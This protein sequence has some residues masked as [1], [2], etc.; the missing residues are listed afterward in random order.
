MKTRKIINTVLIIAL[1]IVAI[2]MV[3]ILLNN[4]NSPETVNYTELQQMIK[5]NGIT[6]VYVEGSYTVYARKVGSK[7]EES[8][9]S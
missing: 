3:S 9:F 1:L 4:A 5:S 2:V 6:N 7:I 8:Q